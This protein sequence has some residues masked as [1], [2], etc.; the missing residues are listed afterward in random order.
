[1]DARGLHLAPVGQHAADLVL[2]REVI[3]EPN[4]GEPG[5]LANQRANRNH[6][7]V[8]QLLP[9]LPSV[10]GLRGQHLPAEAVVSSV[11]LEEAQRLLRLGLQPLEVG[12]HLR[13][14]LLLRSWALVLVLAHRPEEEGLALR[15]LLRDARVSEAERVTV[16]VPFAAP[17][18][19]HLV[20]KRF[21]RAVKVPA[22]NRLPEEP[23]PAPELPDV[24]QE[25]EQVGARPNNVVELLH[26]LAAG[27]LR[28]VGDQGRE[29]EEGGLLAVGQAL[30]GDVT[31]GVEE[32]L[33]LLL[34]HLGDELGVV[35]G[36]LVLADIVGAAFRPEDE[37]ATDAGLRGHLEGVASRVVLDLLRAGRRGLGSRTSAEAPERVSA[38]GHDLPS[39][40]EQGTAPATREHREADQ[41]LLCNRSAETVPRSNVGK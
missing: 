8:Q 6:A 15:V 35:L 19:D 39:D 14:L 38:S 16:G 7:R 37:E 1:M 10:Q 9:D 32:E 2:P 13:Q 17:V 40:K 3:E 30:D 26:H 12:H 36:Q 31:D 20:G 24:R 18:L 4:P 28:R 23:T 5:E 27:L 29:R 21:E 25:Q 41:N 22:G 33:R 34:R 11:V